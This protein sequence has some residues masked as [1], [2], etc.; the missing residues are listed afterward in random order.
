MHSGKEN[1]AHVNLT[2]LQAWIDAGRIDPS[3]PITPKELIKAKLIGR[4]PDGIKLLAHG[5]YEKPQ[6]GEAI[7]KQPIDICVSR[8]SAKAI[9]AIEAAGGK[10]VTRYY[11]KDAIRKLIAGKSVN[12][13]TPLPLGKEFVEPALEKLN[14]APYLYRLP[15]PVGR[16]HIEY[17]RDPAHR[18]YLSHQLKPGESPS[19]FFQVPSKTIKKKVVKA[20]TAEQSDKKLF[21][22]R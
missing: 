9:E 14:A 22:L 12:T 13:S 8:A 16:W 4:I 1:I 20:K 19:L 18:G 2:R 5:R 6:E 7:I 21:S 15:D 3:Q 11:T 10:V 17:Y